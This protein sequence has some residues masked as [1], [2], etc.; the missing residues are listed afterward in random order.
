VSE[1]KIPT[2]DDVR[3]NPR[4]WIAGPGEAVASRTKCPHGYYLTSSCPC[5]DADEESER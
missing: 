2:V 4:Y 1:P 5:C 3:R